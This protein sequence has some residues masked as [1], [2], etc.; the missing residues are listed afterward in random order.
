[1]NKKNKSKKKNSSLLPLIIF[2]VFVLSAI[3]DNMD[4][5][6]LLG[7]IVIAVVIGICAVIFKLVKKTITNNIKTDFPQH[8]HD[9]LSA[10]TLKIEAYD[11]FEHY[12]R[13][14]DGFLAAGIIDKA[15]YKVLYEKYKKTLK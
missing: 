2:A 9:R 4:E 5:D 6:I 1:M 11:S 13:Q 7:I 10:N 12:K 15:E 14:I 3:G 8:S